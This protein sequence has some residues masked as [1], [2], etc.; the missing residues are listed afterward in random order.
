VE[1]DEVRPE[2]VDDEPVALG[3][4]APHRSEDERDLVNERR[5]EP[6]RCHIDEKTLGL[7][8]VPE[9]STAAEQVRP[10][11]HVEIAGPSSIRA[12]RRGIHD[13]PGLGG[14]RLDVIRASWPGRRLDLGEQ[15]TLCD[16]CLLE[17]DAVA[18]HESRQL[19]EQFGRECVGTRELLRVPDE[20]QHG[21]EVRRA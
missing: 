6:H 4:V 14:Q 7:G 18:G 2:D 3:E 12:N 11:H 15:D 17:T 19:H 1:R 10:F 13:R 8:V 16:V 20:R 9:S 21:F 5:R